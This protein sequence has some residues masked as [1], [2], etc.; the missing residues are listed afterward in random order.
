MP[1]KLLQFRQKI[2]QIKKN[3]LWRWCLAITF[4][5]YAL[6]WLSLAMVWQQLPPVVP[7]YYNLNWGEAQ[8]VT[9]ATLV[10]IV[11]LLM[12]LSAINVILALVYFAKSVYLS[13]LMLIGNLVWCLLANA[14]IMQIILSV[15]WI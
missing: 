6:L 3:R 15:T 1:Q 2:S 8:L 10:K 5:L 14:A 9:P 4:L 13:Y 11:G 7:L 12:T